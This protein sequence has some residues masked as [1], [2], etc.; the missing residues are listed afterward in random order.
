MVVL[1]FQAFFLLF[2]FF[3]SIRLQ[4]HLFSNKLNKTISLR[5]FSFFLFSSSHF[6]SSPAMTCSSTK[7]QHPLLLYSFSP[8]FFFSIL[9]YSK[10]TSAS[11]CSYIL[12]LHALSPSFFYSPFFDNQWYTLF[13]LL[14][15]LFSGLLF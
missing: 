12:L 15:F 9:F 7:P 3:F 8:C 5:L 1:K 13:L 6:S 2:S 14:P 10:T 11:L 4:F